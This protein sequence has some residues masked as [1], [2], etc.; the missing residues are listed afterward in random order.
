MCT[1]PCTCSFSLQLLKGKPKSYSKKGTISRTRD[2]T[3]LPI[4]NC[5]MTNDE[6]KGKTDYTSLAEDE[7]LKFIFEH[8]YWNIKHISI[9]PYHI[10]YS[11]HSF[12]LRGDGHFKCCKTMACVEAGTTFTLLSILL[13]ALI[14]ILFF[15]T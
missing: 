15:G 8:N 13:F 3:Q 4:H 10:R 14:C 2:H 1:E 7:T 11:L 6:A 5:I 9:D 12:Q